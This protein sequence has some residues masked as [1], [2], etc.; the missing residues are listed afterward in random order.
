M[1]NRALVAGE[2]ATM[3]RPDDGLLS[4]AMLVTWAVPGP[5]MLPTATDILFTVTV[6]CGLPAEKLTVWLAGGAYVG[7]FAMYATLL[8]QH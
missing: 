4:V 6:P 2:G 3:V 8:P 7:S 5:P 1:V